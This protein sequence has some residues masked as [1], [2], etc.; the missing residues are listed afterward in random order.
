MRSGQQ[1]TPVGGAHARH[2]ITEQLTDS[3]SSVTNLIPTLGQDQ[4]PIYPDVGIW[5]A[6]ADTHNRR[7]PESV[8]I[9]PRNRTPSGPKAV[10]LAIDSSRFAPFPKTSSM[11][12][13][14]DRWW[15]N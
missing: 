11:Y 7:H 6:G 2:A 8:E 9:G 1:R 3:T 4:I 10:I 12:L 15:F 5:D 13:R 14:S